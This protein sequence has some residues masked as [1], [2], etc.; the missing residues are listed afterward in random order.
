MNI[1]IDIADNQFHGNYSVTYHCI[2]RILIVM[3]NESQYQYFDTAYRTGSD[4]WTHVPYHKLAL[5][6]LPAV[7]PNSIILDVGSGRGIWAFKLID[8]GFRVIGVDYVRSIVDKVNAD[9]KLLSYAERARFIQGDAT[10][11]PFTDASFPL[12]TDIGV[13][14]HLKSDE[15]S[16]Y[17]SELNRVVANQGYVLSV[18]LSAETPTFLGFHPKLNNESPYEKFGVSYYFF[19]IEEIA[20]LFAQHGF[21][22][23]NQQTHFFQTQSDP[24]DS[25]GMIFT[26]FQKK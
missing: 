8:T 15:W 23:V 18:T 7:A 20:N 14:Q 1:I 4:I 9:I 17:L 26:L 22:V 21:M 13:L 24:G 6:M 25:L 11:L 19:S 16:Q 5:D 10:D 2:C 3:T 12:V